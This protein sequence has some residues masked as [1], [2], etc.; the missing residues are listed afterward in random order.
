MCIRDSTA[1]A[2]SSGIP[3]I[4]AFAPKIDAPQSLSSSSVFSRSMNGTDKTRENAD[5]TKDR[6]EKEESVPGLASPAKKRRGVANRADG[7]N[8]AGS[9]LGRSGSRERDEEVLLPGLASP[10]KKRGRSVLG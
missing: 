4:K 7:F 1:G 2:T 5:R 8:S 9:V 10:A 6:S 3:S